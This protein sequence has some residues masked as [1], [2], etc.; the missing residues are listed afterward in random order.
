ML[1]VVEVQESVLGVRCVLFYGFGSL[2]L[3]SNV[4]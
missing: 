3:L 4:C 1:V 2:G